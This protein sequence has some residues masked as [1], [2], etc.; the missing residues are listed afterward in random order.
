MPVFAVREWEWQLSDRSILLEKGV[1]MDARKVMDS[2]AL[3]GGRQRARVGDAPHP[4]TAH[5]H[6]PQHEGLPVAWGSRNVLPPPRRCLSLGM[7]KV[8]QMALFV[9]EGVHS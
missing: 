4:L 9:K 5:R 6:K 7:L 3:D 8:Q 2:K 1:S